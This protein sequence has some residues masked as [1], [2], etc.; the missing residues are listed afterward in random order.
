MSHPFPLQ[1]S[2][3]IDVTPPRRRR[4]RGWVLAGLVVI[5]IALYR[6]LSIYLSALWFGSLGYSSVY[7][8][9][10]KLK[11]AL[12]LVF[13][14]L[15]AAI[16]RSVFWLLERVFAAHAIERRTI[17][18]NN[19]PVEFSPARFIRPVSWLVAVVFGL[20]YGLEMKSEWQ[21]FALYFNQVP[22]TLH[23]PIFQK[24]LGFYLFSLPVYDSVSSWLVSL[25][26]VIL[27]AAL[28]YSLL[29]IPQQVLKTT[30]KSARSVAFASV[31]CALALFLL[32]LAWRVYLSRFPYL[33][34]DHQT[35]SGVTY[36]EAKYLLPA[37]YL[38]CI[39]LLIA[40]AISVLNAFTKRGLRLL[41]VALAIP[42]T[43]YVVGV[44]IVPAYVTSFI[45]KPN[46]LGRETPY[47][48]QNIAWTRRAFG[49]EQLE[50]REFQ[51]ES[52]VEAFD[53]N[54]NR[55]TLE[56]IRL[57][58]WH[59]LQDTLK[60]IQAIRTYYDFP[61]VD[62]DR[63]SVDGVRQMMVAARE[64]DVGSLPETSRNWINEKLIY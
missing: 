13:T 50:L 19:Q 4:W 33:W 24:P 56:N 47:I 11:L 6:S 17:V 30:A 43:V 32:L 51:A 26:F 59:A 9:I 25:A 60:Q 54:S 37:L 52:S 27:C 64:I 10:F 14:V 3:V 38:V 44:F 18:I 49:L 46:E 22:T 8:Y 62:V 41:L 35:F 28:A 5:F 16:L 55:P 36:T 1:D 63:Y 58:D 40:A 12:F 48:E 29:A 20:F 57:W 23:D 45:V 21:T 31:S 42:V 53:L 61:D 7:W 15:T 2:D 34:E 39:A